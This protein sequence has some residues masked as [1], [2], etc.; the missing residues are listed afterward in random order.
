MRENRDGYG[1]S[2]GTMRDDDHAGP[3]MPTFGHISGAP[4][5]AGLEDLVFC[6]AMWVIPLAV[7]GLSS[8]VETRRIGRLRHPRR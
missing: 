4:V 3:D 8:L 1:A 6:L 5:R 7:L 2:D